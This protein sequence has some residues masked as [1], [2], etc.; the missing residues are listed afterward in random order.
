[1]GAVN[2][3][4]VPELR[5]AVVRL[6]RERDAAQKEAR[7]LSRAIQNM[8]QPPLLVAQVSRVLSKNYAIVRTPNSQEFLVPHPN[9]ELSAGDTVALNQNTL[10]I[11]KIL[12][13]NIDA[14]VASMELDE[15]PRET[16]EDIGGLR[17]ILQDIREVVELPLIHPEVFTKMGIEPPAGVLLEG[18][19]GTGKTL[20]AR[21]VA[22]ATH[23]TFIRLVGS[24][25]V[26]KFIGEG[27]R[28]VREIFALA[29]EKSPSILFI[30]EI[31]AVASRRTPDSQVSDREVQRTLMQLLSELD[32]FN[33]I[34]GV[35]VLAA[36]NRPDILDPAILRPGR[37]D[38]I[39]HFSLPEEKDRGEILKIHTR[40]M[41]LRNVDLNHLAKI[42]DGMS[43]ADIRGMCTEAAMFA[44]RGALDYITE[45]QFIQAMSKLK[46]DHL[47]QKPHNLYM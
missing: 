42:T 44:I 15:K 13:S 39:I 23:A 5:K 9:F 29:R 25:L 33:Q 27:A 12:P 20:V 37:F 21:A 36:S 6:T 4:N 14:F 47:E 1:M 35:K 3:D 19:P 7:E 22:N 34:K 43:G 17:E 2:T 38:R 24:E 31:D 30:D 8:A 11:V 41:P 26:Q 18:P 28:I 45:A 10:A 46:K 16:Y 32:G 40:R